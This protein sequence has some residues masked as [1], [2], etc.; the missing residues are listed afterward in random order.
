MK[1]Q[2]SN[3]PKLFATDR[4]ANKRVYYKTAEEVFTHIEKLKTSDSIRE[5]VPMLYAQFPESKRAKY[6]EAA[7]IKEC[8]HY[9]RGT[10]KSIPFFMCLTYANITDNKPQ[11][12]FPE[13]FFYYSH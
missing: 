11:Q 5:G 2:I 10:D 13:Q 12:F 3:S 7:A 8:L 9:S 4:M 6:G 1:R